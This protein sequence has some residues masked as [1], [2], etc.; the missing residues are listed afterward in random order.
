MFCFCFIAHLA[1]QM[2]HTSPFP[3]FSSPMK[4]SLNWLKEHVKLKESPEEISALLTACGLEVEG[5]VEFSAVRGGLKGLI[6]GQVLTCE[7]HPNADRLKK[8]TVDTGNGKIVPVVCGA[9]NVAP[10]QKV[11]IALPGTTLYPSKGDPFVIQKSKIRGEVSEGMICA[12]DE[13]GTGDGHEGISILPA[14]APVGAYLSDYLHIETDTV[15]EIGLTAN[16]GDAASHRGVAR[17]LAAVLDRDLITGFPQVAFPA[18]EAGWNV[19]IASPDCIR[20]SGAYIS[21]VTV[22]ESPDWL[23]SRLR[24]LG[25]SPVNNIVDITN[26]VLHDLGQPIHAFDAAAVS[27]K[28]IMVRKAVPGAAFMTLDGVERKMSGQELMI[29]SA[30]EPLA[31][32]GIFGGKKSGV[33][34][35]TTAVFIESACFDPGSVRKSAKN[36]GLNTDASFR[37]ERGTDPDMTLPALHKTVA[38]ILELAGGEP[39]AAFIDAYPS[40]VA[41]FPV[42]LEKKYLHSLIGQE[43][44][45]ERVDIILKRLEINILSSDEAGWQLLVPPFKGDVTRPVDVVEEVLRIYGL[46]QIRIPDRVSVSFASG[47]RPDPLALRKKAADFLVA[48][49]FYEIATNSMTRSAYFPEESLSE[50]VWIKNPLSSDM[51]I[52]RKGLL[53]SF[54]EAVAYNK[55]RK[56]RDLRLFELGRVYG[57]KEDKYAESLRLGMILCGKWSQESW[58]RKQEDS[59]FFHLKQ[60]VS[61]LLERLGMSCR[62]SKWLFA[63]WE[64]N[65]ATGAWIQIGPVHPALLKKMDVQGKVFY[66]ELNWD[67]LSGTVSSSVRFETRPAPRFPE[68]RRDLSLIMDAS[69]KYSEICKIAKETDKGL[70][71]EMNVFDVYTGDQV[72]EGKKSYSIGFVL[73]NENKTL[74]EKEIDAFMQQLIINFE[75]KAGATLR[76]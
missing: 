58:H 31:I 68:V 34:T 10:G 52:M 13:I 8:T 14:D 40:A 9:P 67:A 46:D 41:G 19:E 56:S 30:E 23:K 1:E 28:S 75:R 55:N 26:Y 49:G 5:A 16:R 54:L 50:A 65:L 33:S 6:I 2:R 64:N 73:R 51:E 39:G 72:G 21:G 36:H 48:R 29:C 70:I 71:R 24:S 63:P 57:R 20:Y 45:E 11:V 74:E 47:L 44:P 18:D 53:P 59:D 42:R 60:E 43:I 35:E 12:E 15:L 62:E 4:I 7:P 17:D 37:Y 38:L 61:E 69:A 25:L 32:A 66:A 27:G 3:V 76:K 22:K